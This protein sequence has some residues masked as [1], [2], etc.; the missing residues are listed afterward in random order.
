MGK[1]DGV[2]KNDQNKDSEADLKRTEHFVRNGSTRCSMAV[3]NRNALRT[4]LFIICDRK[5]PSI[6]HLEFLTTPHSGET[7]ISCL[8]SIEQGGD[9]LPS[10]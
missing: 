5:E 3:V 8:R 4:F 6:I 7:T 2:Q 10:Y 9:L 1:K